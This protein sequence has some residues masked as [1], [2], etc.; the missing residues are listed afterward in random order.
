[1]PI[2]LKRRRCHH[3]V[4]ESR[5]KP[6]EGVSEKRRCWQPTSTVSSGFQ[7]PVT[8]ATI[9]YLYV[10]CALTMHFFRPTPLSSSV[11]LENPR[12]RPPPFVSD[13]S[14]SLLGLSAGLRSGMWA[15]Y[16]LTHSSSKTATH[17]LKLLHLIF[18]STPFFLMYMLFN[19]LSSSLHLNIQYNL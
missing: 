17:V 8:V 3:W 5:R 15:A 19:L 7:K 9:R 16:F 4:S 14:V 18:T 10:I 11:S 2:I 13:C 1:M 12:P 6:N